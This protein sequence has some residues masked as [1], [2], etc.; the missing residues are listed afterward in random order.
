MD[1]TLANQVRDIA[2]KLSNLSEF[3]GTNVQFNNAFAAAVAD[4]LALPMSLDEFAV[5]WAQVADNIAVD[6]ELAYLTWKASAT[7][8]CTYQLTE[9]HWE[10]MSLKADDIIFEDKSYVRTVPCIN[11]YGVYF[12]YLG[13]V[14]R[15]SVL[16]ESFDEACRFVWENHAKFS[17]GVN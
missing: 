10:D 15:E 9:P 8:K 6:K 4:T 3:I 2:N 12:K 14:G 16:T 17:Y 13:E 5:E 1:N 11:N 7:F